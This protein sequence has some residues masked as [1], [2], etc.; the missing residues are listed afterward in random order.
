MHPTKRFSITSPNEMRDAM[1][2]NVEACEYATESEV[3]RDGLRA[4]VVHDRA[5]DAWLREHVVPAAKALAADPARVLTPAQV[6]A[7][8]KRRRAAGSPM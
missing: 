7:N 1:K 6:R 4:L 2:A 8:A 5:I 3:I